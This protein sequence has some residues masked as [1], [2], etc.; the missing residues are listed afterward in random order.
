MGL[1][2]PLLAE[3]GGEPAHLPGGEGDV[4]D[5]ELVAELSQRLVLGGSR[6][7]G[8]VCVGERLEEVRLDVQVVTETCLR[9]RKVRFKIK[10]KSVHPIIQSF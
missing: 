5:A 10:R 1:Q 7:D 9:A 4:G 2:T 3:P 8:G 6:L